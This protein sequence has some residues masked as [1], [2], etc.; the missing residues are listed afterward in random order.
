[1]TCESNKIP[2]GDDD[3]ETKNDLLLDEM[4]VMSIVDSSLSIRRLK[5]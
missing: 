1:M 5:D 3:G 2:F 4:D